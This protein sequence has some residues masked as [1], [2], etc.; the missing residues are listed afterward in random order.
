MITKLAEAL[1]TLV[2]VRLA[3]PNQVDTCFL[4][5][6][7]HNALSFVD[8]TIFFCAIYFKPNT[9][10][11]LYGKLFE[12]Q[13]VDIKKGYCTHPRRKYSSHI[14]WFKLNKTYDKERSVKLV[15]NRSKN[16]AN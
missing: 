14:F 5:K 13:I 15:P 10:R 6:V 16:I 11:F 3:L 7:Y 12:Y 1:H 9:K 2:K 4:S 8:L